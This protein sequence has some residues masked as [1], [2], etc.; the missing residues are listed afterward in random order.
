[1]LFRSERSSERSLTSQNLMEVAARFAGL[2]TPHRH[3]AG[4]RFRSLLRIRKARWA[5]F[6]SG[7]GD[8]AVPGGYGA[9]VTSKRSQKP[10][11]GQGVAV[12]QRTSALRTDSTEKA[13]KMT[14]SADSSRITALATAGW[15]G[16]ERRPRRNIKG[17]KVPGDRGAHGGSGEFFEGW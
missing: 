9:V 17:A 6:R 1:M 16:S 5:R 7:S 4:P 10:M 2:Q 14:S 8:G 13:S 11:E 15:R 3:D 12:R